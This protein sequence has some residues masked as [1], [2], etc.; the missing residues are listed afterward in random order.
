MPDRLFPDQLE[1]LSP[2]E[3]LKNYSFDFSDDIPSGDSISVQNS[4]VTAVDDDAMDTTATIVSGKSISGT[5]LR[6]NLAS[7]SEGKNYLVIYR[8]AMTN[9]GET[10]EKYLKIKCRPPSAV[11]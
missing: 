10:V 8:A 9:S 7:F 3:S 1:F 2:T 6:A 5:Q 11:G 4:T